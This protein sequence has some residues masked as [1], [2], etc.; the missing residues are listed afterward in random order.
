VFDVF[1]A[2][3]LVRVLV[4]S[5]RRRFDIGLLASAAGALLWAGLAAAGWYGR[6][7]D[8]F[9]ASGAWLLVFF[10]PSTVPRATAA[11]P[12]SAT[13]ADHPIA[14][15]LVLAAMLLVPFTVAWRRAE[16]ISP[17]SDDASALK[18]LALVYVVPAL[19][20]LAQVVC[21]AMA[22]VGAQSR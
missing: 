18:K 22:I 20:V 7:A 3:I 1:L 8:A 6:G 15:K 13:L 5:A 2:L 12:L 9:G 21:L 16:R 10:G 4:I 19:L 14:A 11:V 17:L